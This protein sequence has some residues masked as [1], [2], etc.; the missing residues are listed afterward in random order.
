M[1][2]KYNLTPVETVKIFGY[3]KPAA[4]EELELFE[5]N[6][7]L[8]LPQLLFD[9]LSLVRNEELLSD[10][11][12]YFLTD[13]DPC[14]YFSYQYIEEGIED[15]RDGFDDPEFCKGNAFYPYSRIPKEQW[16]ELV[17]NY[18]QIGSDYEGFVFFGIKEKELA[19]ENPPVYM[20]HETDELSDWKLIAHTLS[21]YLMCVLLDA[22]VDEYAAAQD[23]L[24][25]NGWRICEEEYE[26]EE[27]LK[28]Q[29]S[30]KG[31]DL[32]AMRKYMTI[33]GAV[34]SFY[35]YCFDEE[36]KIFYIVINS[37]SIILIKDVGS[38][39]KV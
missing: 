18:L 34:D 36:E 11:D 10:S 33:H 29:L 15:C 5:K 38:D 16:P 39:I 13:G 17:E 25:E 3:T 9:F 7:H 37:E 4:K 26:N 14:P 24:E 12:I 19:L 20:L 32:S 31:I 23:A 21:E 28:G 27:E 2:I 8:K 35:R 22:L 1:A 30:Q 6:N